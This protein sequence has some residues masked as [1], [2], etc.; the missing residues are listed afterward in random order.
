MKIEM[1][2]KIIYQCVLSRKKFFLQL[3]FNRISSSNVSSIDKNEILS[4]QVVKQF[5]RTVLENVIFREKWFWT[6]L[7]ITIRIK[8]KYIP[9]AGKIISV[10]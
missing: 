3:V 5:N 10:Y 9:I 8:I 7:T 2:I 6:F 4:A 1:K